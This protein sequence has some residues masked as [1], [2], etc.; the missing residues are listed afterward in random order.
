MERER[1]ISDLIPKAD[2]ADEDG[3]RETKRIPLDADVTFIHPAEISGVALD[4]SEGGLKVVTEKPLHPGTRCIALVQLPSGD[5]THERM[6]VVWT[7]RTTQG[8]VAGL[9]FSS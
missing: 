1:R 6:E 5:E 7:K 4:A 9:S 2:D 8:W 3:Q